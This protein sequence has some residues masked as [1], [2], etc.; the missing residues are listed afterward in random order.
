MEEQNI[1]LS[2]KHFPED[3]QKY[4]VS[5]NVL[6]QTLHEV[7]QSF[8]GKILTPAKKITTVLLSSRFMVASKCLF[9]IALQGYYYEAYI[10]LR[11]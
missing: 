8:I 11:S 10:L 1:R 3:L 7:N 6:A 2:R 9:N 5:V 4:E